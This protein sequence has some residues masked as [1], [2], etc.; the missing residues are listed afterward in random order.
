MCTPGS[1][2][3]SLKN[4]F[5]CLFFITAYRFDLK[6]IRKCF[7][8]STFYNA[9][10]VLCCIRHKV[11]R[12]EFCSLEV[13]TEKP[14]DSSSIHSIIT[15]PSDRNHIKTHGP[16][17]SPYYK[18][19]E[20]ENTHHRPIQVLNIHLNTYS[21][22]NMSRPVCQDLSLLGFRVWP[23]TKNY[24]TKIS[25]GNHDERQRFNYDNSRREQSPRHFWRRVDEDMCDYKHPIERAFQV[26]L[27]SVQTRDLTQTFQE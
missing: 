27:E 20:R 23:L 19:T 8:N 11:S 1:H 18:K 17:L 16:F 4:H 13:N 14:S 22:L 6:S 9:T 15:K 7:C 12:Q 24:M 5:D 2:S 26:L 10:F 21:K 3:T 25:A